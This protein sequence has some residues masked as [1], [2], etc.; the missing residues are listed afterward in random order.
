LPEADEAEAL[1][2]AAV[3]ERFRRPLA[4]AARGAM[5]ANVALMHVLMEATDEGEARGILAGAAAREGGAALRA[6]VDLWDAHP[7][8][9]AAVKAVLARV[10]H[11]APSEGEATVRALA[12][13]FDAAAE[14]APEASVALYTLGSPE[15]MH[16]ATDEIV[17]VLRRWGV[18][19]PGRTMLELGCGIGRFEAALAPALSLAVGI[20]VSPAMLRAARERCRRFANAAFVRTSGLDLAAFRDTSFDLVL[21]A[22]SFPY[23]V[24]AGPALLARHMAEAARVLRPGGDLVILNLSYRGDLDR[25]RLDLAD[26]AAGAFAIRRNGVQGEFRLW[27]GAV[28]HLVRRPDAAARPT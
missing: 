23:L 9:F 16:A 27:D 25:D 15:L 20:D 14:A 7:Q 21:A 1:W 24:Q 18:V 13:A 12:A 8:A 11:D 2:L 28:F 4:L 3:P 22:D 26:L 19:A 6:L 17:A 10:T 5:P